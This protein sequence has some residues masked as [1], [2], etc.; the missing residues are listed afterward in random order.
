M[1]AS[2]AGGTSGQVDVREFLPDDAMGL[3]ALDAL[4]TP[5]AL[6]ADWDN[7]ADEPHRTLIAVDGGRVVG[8]AHYTLVGTGEAWVEGVRV[9]PELRRR[10]IGRQLLNAALA[11]AGRH[12]ALRTRCAVPAD[13]EAARSLATSTG[14]SE[15]ARF[16]ALV[17]NG[18]PGAAADGARP[19]GHGDLGFVM[20]GFRGQWN[21]QPDR[22]PLVALGWRLRELSAQIL[23]GAIREERLWVTDAPPGAAL[24]LRCDADRVVGAIA[25][26]GEASLGALLDAIRADMIEPGRIAVFAASGAGVANQLAGMSFQP[27]PWAREGF[28]VLARRHPA[29]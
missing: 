11:E 22:A 19:A 14:F 20:S 27:D 25:A 24:F 4:V 15:E 12:G 7:W 6:P 3:A 28:L 9:L 1:T 26:D 2:R 5:P 13:A 23:G 21:P 16:D 18:A 8:A 10:G 17:A 29:R